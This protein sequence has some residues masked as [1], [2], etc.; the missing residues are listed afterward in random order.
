MNQKTYH[1]LC[2][3]IDQSVV[4]DE[5]QQAIRDCGRKATSKRV[6]EVW[7]RILK[8]LYREAKD[9]FSTFVKSKGI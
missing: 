1:K 5:I 8:N 4:I 9:S 2:K 7:Y 6:K 3:W